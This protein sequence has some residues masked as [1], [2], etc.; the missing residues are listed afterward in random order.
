VAHQYPT[1]V[2]VQ[3]INQGNLSVH[4]AGGW[5]ELPPEYAEKMFDVESAYGEGRGIER[6]NSSENAIELEI[7]H[8]NKH[9]GAVDARYYFKHL[10]HHKINR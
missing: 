6:T 1:T 2:L 3:A 8:I 7:R 10:P 5:V 4:E 9:Q